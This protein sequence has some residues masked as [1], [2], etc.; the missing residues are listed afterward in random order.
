MFDAKRFLKDHFTYPSNVR[1]AFLRYD[2]EAPKL[3]AIEKWF[4][5]GAIPGDQWPILLCILELDKG[6]P[7]SVAG[8]VK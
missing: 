2:L 8:Y 5:R 3:A 7:V 1:V 6:A 4:I